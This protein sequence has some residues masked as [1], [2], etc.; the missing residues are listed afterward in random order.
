MPSRHRLAISDCLL[1]TGDLDSSLGELAA[2]LTAIDQPLPLNL[3][4]AIPARAKQAHGIYFCSNSSTNSYA[5]YADAEK[6]MPEAQIADFIRRSNQDLFE[7]LNQMPLESSH[8]AGDEEMAVE[9]INKS[10]LLNGRNTPSTTNVLAVSENVV[11]PTNDEHQV[12]VTQ[13]TAM[14]EPA[15][16]AEPLDIDC[17]SEPDTVLQAEDQLLLRKHIVRS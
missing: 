5:G 13:G 6:C 15:N 12:T 4:A 8:L 16:E 10:A 3:V 11:H 17:P 14:T 9:D 1:A 2:R 7:K